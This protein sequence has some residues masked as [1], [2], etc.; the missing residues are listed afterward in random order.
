MVYKPVLC[1]CFRRSHV[2]PHCWAMK[3]WFII[4]SEAWW[5]AHKIVNPFLKQQ[6]RNLQKPKPT[7]NPTKTKK[8]RFYHHLLAALVGFQR[9]FW[10]HIGIIKSKSWPCVGH[11][12]NPTTWALSKPSL[13]W[14]NPNTTSKHWALTAVKCKLHYTCNFITPFPHLSRSFWSGDLLSK[15]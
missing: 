5:R 11:P 2:L 10:E 6:Q 12:K 7:K 14:E 13:S 1:G 9:A 8:L 3:L 4:T 15:Y